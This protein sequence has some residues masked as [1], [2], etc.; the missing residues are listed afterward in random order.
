ML[1]RFQMSYLSVPVKART[2]GK[3]LLVLVVVG[4]IEHGDYIGPDLL[5]LVVHWRRVGRGVSSNCKLAGPS[6]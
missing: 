6:I 2:L 1:A 3:E 4:V 5:E